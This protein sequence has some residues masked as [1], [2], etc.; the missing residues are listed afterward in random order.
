MKISLFYIL[1][2]QCFISCISLPKDTF[3]SIELVSSKMEKIYINS[4]NWGVSDD[5]QRTIV[6][7]DKSAL[8]ERDYQKKYIERLEPFIYSFSNDTL[9]LFFDEE[10][11]YNSEEKF[12]TIHIEYIALESKKFDKLRSMAF[13]PRLAYSANLAHSFCLKTT[14]HSPR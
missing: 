11:T 14:A 13:I 6:T 9:K 3:N 4:I 7:K 1:S 12:S 2:F 5:H 10:I 8:K